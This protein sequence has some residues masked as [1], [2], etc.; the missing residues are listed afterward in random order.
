MT[1]SELKAAR[2]DGLST[3]AALVLK[4]GVCLGRLPPAQRAWALALPAAALPPG[5]SATEAEVNAA[6]LRCLAAE[7]SF[8]DT[9]HVELRRWLVD[10]GFWRRDGFGRAYE[11]M[12]TAELPGSMQ[13]AAEALAGIDA[14]A[15]VRRQRELRQAGRDARRSAWTAQQGGA[16][17]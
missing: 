15:W 17:G 3:L 6:L 14:G 1:G 2:R 8:L 13:A 16:H 4:T 12:P 9:D 11:R 7:C 5:R 10:C